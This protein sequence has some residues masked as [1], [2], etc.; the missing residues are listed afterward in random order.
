MYRHILIAT[1][2][3][4]LSDRALEH[5]LNLAKALDAKALLVHVRAPYQP[6]MIPTYPFPV[7]AEGDRHAHEAAT[8]KSATEILSAATARADAVGVRATSLMPENEEPWRG[9]MEAATEHEADVIVMASHGRKALN[10][11]LLGSETQQLLAHSAQPV[12]VV[13]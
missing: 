13:R 10:A 9:L 2:G 3:S 6:L 8:Q 5:G 7:L 11:L 4:D 1:D 12:L